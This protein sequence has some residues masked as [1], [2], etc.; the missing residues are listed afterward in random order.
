MLLESY[1]ARACEQSAARVRA[2]EVKE[3]YATHIDDLKEQI[4][5]WIGGVHGS[6]SVMQGASVGY[7]FVRLREITLQNPQGLVDLP[8]VD[9]T[10]GFDI[11][12]DCS[13]GT[14]AHVFT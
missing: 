8:E 12:I 1:A 14:Q 11:A 5:L 4:K 2:Q 3:A 7:V 6:H 10:F 9:G 13:V